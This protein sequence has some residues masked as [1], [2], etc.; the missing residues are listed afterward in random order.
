MY[1]TKGIF[2]GIMVTGNTKLQQEFLR[3]LWSTLKIL[4][5][6]LNFYHLI[7]PWKHISE[8]NFCCCI[9][10][11]NIPGLPALR[12]LVCFFSQSG[13]ETNKQ[14]ELYS[15]FQPQAGTAKIV[16]HSTLQGSTS[17]AAYEFPCIWQDP[18]MRSPGLYSS[19]YKASKG[20]LGTYAVR[21]KCNPCCSV[22]L[23]SLKH[24]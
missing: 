3:T 11:K 16:P 13:H 20:A 19:M 12:F 5:S 8:N 10:L 21:W 2:K 9:T 14:L 6:I 7:L 4:R 17:Y 24:R 23:Y 18:T 22:P 1:E 15:I